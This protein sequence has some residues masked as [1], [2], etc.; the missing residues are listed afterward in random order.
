MATSVTSYDVAVV[1]LGAMG[2]AAL[3]QLAKRG[4]KAVG[5]DRFSPPHDLGSTHGETRITRQAIGEGAFYVPLALRAHEIWKELEAETGESLLVETGCLI[6]APKDANPDRR[7]RTSFLMRTREA[8]EQY[9]IAHEIIGAD[10]IRHRYPQFAA[11]DTEIGYFEPGGGYVRP[12]ACVGMQ[13]RRA[14]QLGAA[15]RRNTIVH[16]IR[17]TGSHVSVETSEGTVLAG[18]V[19]VSAGSWAPT[20]LGA[21]FKTLLEPSRQ[22]MHW[23]GVEQTFQSHWEHGPVFI[24]AHGPGDDDLFYGF[25]SM[26][27]SGA[28]KTANEQ[29]GRPVDPDTMRRDVSE[30]ES[31]AVYD[32]H[33][34]GRLNGVLPGRLNAVTCLYTQTPDSAFLIDRHPDFERVLVVSPCSGHGFKHSAAI[35]DVAAQ[36]MTEGRSRIDLSAFALSRFSTNAGA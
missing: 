12:E 20:L 14:E 9:G 7:S 25:P 36:I 27:G 32:A 21:P 17:Q 24:W 34:S 22:M 28:I 6:I 2:S 8:A 19:I 23:F 11:K 33:L 4:V 15:L 1:G 10:E 29:Y 35:G 26:P 13:L 5:I 31:S 16:S 3:Y 30:A 18:Q